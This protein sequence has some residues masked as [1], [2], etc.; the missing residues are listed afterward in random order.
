M[1]ESYAQLR[2][3][4]SGLIS[5]GEL[6]QAVRL[7]DHAL[8]G[9]ADDAELFY[10][11]GLLLARLHLLSQAEFDFR[12]CVAINPDHAS[13]WM[14]LGS[15]HFTHGNRKAAL[16]ARRKAW[17]LNPDLPGLVGEI[18]LE[19]QF[20]CDWN[21]WEQDIQRIARSLRAGVSAVVPLM[22]L[23]LLDD[24]RL[25]GQA[26]GALVKSV[27]TLP[28]QSLACRPMPG[29][30]IRIGYVTPH[31]YAH[32]VL[33][34][35]IGLLACHDRSRFEV[36][37]VMTDP[38]PKGDDYVRRL[39]RSVEHFV[40][41]R[42]TRDDEGLVSKLRALELDVAIDL[43]GHTK[44][45]RP[46][47]FARRVAPVQMSW[48]GYMGTSALPTM[49]YVL[50]DPV[51]LLPP[52]RLYMTERVIDMPVCFQPND[53]WRRIAVLTP[54]RRACDLPRQGFVFCCF[55]QMY[56]LNPPVF[57]V[58]MRILQRIDGSVLWLFVPEADVRQRLQRTAGLAGVSPQRIVFADR[59]PAHR[60]LARY[61][62]V[63]L[64]LDT[65]PY[66]AGTT[67]SDALWVGVPVLSM[68]GQS[69]VSRMGASLLN[70]LGL[71]ELLTSDPIDYENKAV[72]LASDP[73]AL[74]GLR[75]R[76][77]QARRH[78]ALFDSVSYARVL[79]TAVTTAV[80]R[81][82]EGLEPASFAVPSISADSIRSGRKR[83]PLRLRWSLEFNFLRCELGDWLARFNRLR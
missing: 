31:F 70:A 55:N 30:R 53:S 78:S 79:E 3:R 8:Q 43:D 81:Q 51:A 18:R 69:L 45:G 63:D 48:L 4:V 41:M 61:R 57:A 62:R 80:A 66:N 73:V 28:V 36:F 46:G 35:T 26:A 68:A 9:I 39:R 54:S 65:W 21:G 71:Q 50:A 72:A 20:Q 44:G 19:M 67:A 58:W 23:A 6:K 15:I 42:A 27:Y 10:Q 59:V 60:Y 40:D 52:A 11:R 16:E 1:G 33:M 12:R 56:K 74:K 38:V 77:R 24:P 64:F 49:D 47:V 76:L 17:A 13:S 25:Q 82:C 83:L 2:L 37:A 34:L 14:S 29:R 7:L 5:Q 22:S 32:P 75:Q